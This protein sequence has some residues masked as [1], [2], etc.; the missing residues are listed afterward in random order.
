MDDITNDLIDDYLNDQLEQSAVQ[1]EYH[2][3]FEEEEV[4]VEVVTVERENIYAASYA[5][6]RDTVVPEASSAITAETVNAYS[7]PHYSTN[8]SVENDTSSVPHHRLEAFE[9][10]TND[11]YSFER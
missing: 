5:S 1:E 11:I 6:E 4:D 10:S 3:Y 8:Y 2:G 7:D 9:D